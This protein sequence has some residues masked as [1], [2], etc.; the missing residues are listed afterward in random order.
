M[1]DMREDPPAVEGLPLLMASRASRDTVRISP[2]IGIFRSPRFAIPTLAAAARLP[3]LLGGIL[4]PGG[5]ALLG[6][7]DP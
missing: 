6:R 2:A 5:S 3:A 7:M 1:L 4:F